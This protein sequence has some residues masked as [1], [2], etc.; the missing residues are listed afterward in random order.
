MPVSANGLAREHASARSLPSQRSTSSPG[1]KHHRHRLRV[2]STH[3]SVGLA[4]QESHERPVFTRPPDARKGEERMLL[5]CQPEPHLGL[6]A[7]F[8]RPFA[9]GRNRHDAAPRGIG[10]RIAPEAAVQVAYVGDRS[11]ACDLRARK[12]PLHEIELQ[13]AVRRPPQHRRRITGED[14]VV[15]RQVRRITLERPKDAPHLVD[16]RSHVVEIAHERR[17]IGGAVAQVNCLAVL[18]L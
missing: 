18:T 1:S 11:T 17:S 14:L 16:R 3:R 15:G 12:S 10:Q 8:S 9:E 4:G 5:L 7:G 6:P 2:H 13:A